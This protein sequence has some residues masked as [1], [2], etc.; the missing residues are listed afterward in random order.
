MGY[1][2]NYISMDPFDLDNS[3]VNFGLNSVFGHSLNR[4]NSR[5]LFGEEKNSV[6]IPN[7]RRTS[8]FDENE[9]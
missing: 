4:T 5:G 2:H 8:S 9:E 6:T 1:N 3:R 7:V